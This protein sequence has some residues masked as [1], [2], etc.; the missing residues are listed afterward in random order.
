[1]KYTLSFLSLSALPALVSAAPVD[2]RCV[3]DD[4]E[5][6]VCLSS[7]AKRVISVAPGTTEL[8]FTAGADTRVIAIDD[9]SNYPETVQS[10]PRVGGYPNTSVEAILAMKPDLIVAWSGGND[11]RKSAQ[12]EQ[13]GLNVF[14][15]DPMDFDG[16]ASVVRRLGTLMGTEQVA[17]ENADNYY[18]RY[19]SL[20][21]KYQQAEP[22][23]VFFEIW[24]NPLMTVNGGQII[25]H[26][27]ELCGGVN[28][29]ADA[30]PRVPQVS[31]EAVLAQNPEAIVSSQI[32]QNNHDIYSRWQ[33]YQQIY[34]VKHD[35]LFT[36]EG[37]LITRPTFRTLDGAEILCQQLQSVRTYKAKQ[38]PTRESAQGK[39]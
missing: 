11:S 21:E 29:F 10:L 23:R 7:P 38:N 8:V 15:S 34:A 12:L 9:H 28:V 22:V 20:Q 18:Q 27:I 2:T 5:R 35:F 36:V 25:S 14:Y 19:L 31:I 1:M 6:R 30:R 37:D 24:D 3:V 16:I 26:S 33:R 32:V 39:H 17:E 13:V 4:L